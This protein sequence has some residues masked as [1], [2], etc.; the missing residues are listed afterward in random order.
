MVELRP[1]ALRPGDTVA[2]V[3]PSWGGP[4]ELPA[5]YRR[6]CRRWRPPATGFG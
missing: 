5:P 2:V 1:P 4:A 6:H 3:S